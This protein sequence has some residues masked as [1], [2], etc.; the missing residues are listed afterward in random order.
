MYDALNIINGDTNRQR[1]ES[2]EE[3]NLKLS[4]NFWMKM[5]TWIENSK[6]VI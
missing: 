4:A 5:K 1:K 2:S 3:Q 6:F